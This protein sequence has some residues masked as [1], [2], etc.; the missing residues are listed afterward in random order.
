[1]DGSVLSWAGCIKFR[2]YL[3]D[4]RPCLFSSIHVKEETRHDLTWF[5]YLEDHLLFIWKKRQID[6]TVQTK[7]G[8]QKMELIWSDLLWVGFVLLLLLWKTPFILHSPGLKIVKDRRMV[9][10]GSVVRELAW[11]SFFDVY[12]EE[13][14]CKGETDWADIV[15]RRNHWKEVEG[16]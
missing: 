9:C 13:L 2:I 10:N 8:K 3:E 14:H 5:G 15:T 12:L 7:H 16:V 6:L 1:M 4:G 11:I